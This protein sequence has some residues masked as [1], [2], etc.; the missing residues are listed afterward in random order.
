MSVHVYQVGVYKLE[1]YA[2]DMHVCMHNGVCTCVSMH[3]WLFR[4]SEHVICK[5]CLVLLKSHNGSDANRVSMYLC[6]R[7]GE[8]KRLQSQ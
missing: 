1:Q 8:V 4:R 6:A 2:R 5:H 3:E 7:A